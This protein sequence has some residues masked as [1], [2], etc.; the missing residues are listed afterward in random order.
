VAWLATQPEARA[1]AG[2]LI[3]TPSFFKQRG[4]TFP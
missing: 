4:I 1:L 2:T 3:S